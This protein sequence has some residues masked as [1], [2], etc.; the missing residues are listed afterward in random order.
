MNWTE[1]MKGKIHIDHVVPKS[2]FCYEKPE[3]PEFKICWGLNNLQPLW[4]YDNLAKRAK[5][6][7]EWLAEKHQTTTLR[8]V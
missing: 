3:D 1:F 4:D 8:I 2:H 6:L 5:M 7:E